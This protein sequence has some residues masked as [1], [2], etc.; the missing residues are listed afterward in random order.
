MEKSKHYEDLLLQLDGLLCGETDAVANMANTAALLFQTLSQ[1]NWA[2]F[3]I[4]RGNE[5]V[6]GPFQGKPACVR[7]ALGKGVCGTAAQ[8]AQTLVVPDVHAFAGHIACD[9]ASQSEIVIPI[10][11]NGSV[12]GV[13][14][15]DSPI[16]ERFDN[17]DKLFLEKVVAIFTAHT[18]LSR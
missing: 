7:I 13:L 9:V 6:L 12:R 3:Y 11:Y 16:R 18:D 1:L 17:T 14:D 4:L 2:G 5:L 15:I 8:K 10:V